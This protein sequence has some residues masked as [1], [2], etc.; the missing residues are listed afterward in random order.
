MSYQYKYE[1]SNGGYPICEDEKFNAFW[2]YQM[3]HHE[4]SVC[5]QTRHEEAMYRTNMG[6]VC[7]DC[8]NSIKDD[9]DTN[10]DEIPQIL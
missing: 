5:Q 10:E 9:P 6:W 7:I 3:T 4:C 1:G 2:D 8:Y